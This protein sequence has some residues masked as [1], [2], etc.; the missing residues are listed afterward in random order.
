MKKK[1]FTYLSIL[2]I[3]A[4][5][6][7]ACGG[8]NANEPATSSNEANTANSNTTN[9]NTTNSDTT[10]E[11][12]AEPVTLRLAT[13]DAAQS[14]YE[15]MIADFEAANPNIHIEYEILPEDT[16][17]TIMQT[18]LANNNAP[19]IFA[20]TSGFAEP[21]GVGTLANAGYLLNLSD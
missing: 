3:L 14:G 21:L 7:T 4:A 18:Q 19:D 6:L 20:V 16:G 10:E 1:F 9:S 2:L 13:T 15:E 11:E 8:Q 12:V 5:L 17:N